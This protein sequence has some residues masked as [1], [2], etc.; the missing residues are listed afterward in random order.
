VSQQNY[1][2]F[3]FPVLRSPN[4]LQINN[5]QLLFLSST[6]LFQYSNPLHFFCSYL[7]QY[8]LM[9]LQQSL[10]ITSNPFIFTLRCFQAPLK[11]PRLLGLSSGAIKTYQ[12]K[13]C[14]FSLERDYGRP[15]NLA[16]RS[17]YPIKNQ[18]T[19][20]EHK[21][22]LRIVSEKLSLK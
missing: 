17:L 3:F 4:N 11:Y 16:E 18:I 12:A 1:N 5:L 9:H 13:T 7:E 21:L 10:L 20:T 2:H 8:L 19:K 22:N 15:P 14:T 6:S